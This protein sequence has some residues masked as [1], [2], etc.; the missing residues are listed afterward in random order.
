MQRKR[1][2]WKL[3]LLL[4][5]Q[6]EWFKK[7]KKRWDSL[8]L[9]KKVWLVWIKHL[10]SHNIP[11]SQSRVQRKALMLIFSHFHLVWVFATLW[12]VNHDVLLSIRFSRQGNGRVAMASSRGSSWLR[13]KTFILYHWATWEAQRKARVLFHSLKAGKSEDATEEKLEDSWRLFMRFKERNCIHSMKMQGE[14]ASADA[15]AAWSYPDLAEIIN[16]GG[17]SENILSM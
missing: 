3:K 5:W 4:H 16:E 17:Y 12:S 2:L 14:T 13:H 11:L 1:S 7:K 10:V 6:H 15:E 8:I 9:M